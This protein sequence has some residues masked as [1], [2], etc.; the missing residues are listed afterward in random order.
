MRIHTGFSFTL[1][2]TFICTVFSLSQAQTPRVSTVNVKA[3]ADR[4]HISA[5]GDIV[6]LR[7][8]V[9]SESGDVVFESGA[10]NGN[11]LDWKMTDA[12]GVRVAPGTYLVTVTFRTATGK[13]RKRV[14]Q[15]TVDEAE[16]P[17]T[18]ATP[19][20]PQ[21]VEATVTTSGTVS[22]N[23][24]AKFASASTITNSII[25]ESAGKIG[26][27]AASPVSKL[28]ILS[29]STDKPPRLQSTG[30]TSFA[31]GWDFYQGTTPKGYV[32]VPGA[33]VNIGPGEMLLYGSPGVK[34]SLWAGGS[35]AVTILTD[36]KVGIGTVTP[37]A[38][39]DIERGANDLHGIHVSSGDENGITVVNSSAINS[40]YSSAAIYGSS[41]NVGVVGFSS[42]GVAVDGVTTSG[43][44]IYGIVNSEGGGFA[45]HFSGKVQVDGSFINNSDRNSKTNI[46]AIDPRSILLRLAALPIQAWNYK[47]EPASYRHVGPMAQDFRAA[48]GLGID[49]KGISSVDADGVALASIQSLYQMMQEKDRQIERLRAQ[50]VHLQRSV[51]QRG[52]RKR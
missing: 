5:E 18:T 31:A 2:I 37:S 4:V 38:T 33:G 52:R 34:T 15:V 43:T 32:G 24:I 26:I 36:G 29:A 30:T 51:E 21:A 20:A 44:A 19:A 1:A 9:V 27:N 13:L 41:T 42:A 10:I 47:T 45:G 40:G 46:A 6:E 11:T 14:E 39:L 7:L 3:E 35:R 17:S 22:A 25:T 16:K 12:Q 23:K 8:E 28:H 50:V 49:D 48:F